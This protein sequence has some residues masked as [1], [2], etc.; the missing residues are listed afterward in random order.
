MLLAVSRLYFPFF[1]MTAAWLHTCCFFQCDPIKK[2]T[3]HY[4]NPL[5]F[6]SCCL[7]HF[8]WCAAPMD[9]SKYL[10]FVRCIIE[11]DKQGEERSLP[12][13][14]TW[15]TATLQNR[16]RGSVA[17]CLLFPRPPVLTVIQFLS[18][19]SQDHRFRSALWGSACSWNVWY[20]YQWRNWRSVTG[21]QIWNWLSSSLLV[22]GI[23]C[24]DN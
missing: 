15:N 1:I 7:N 2:K 16:R 13:H 5:L 22:W 18:L 14:T 8:L 11:G 23:G 9:T 6:A 21:Q 4:K 19:S 10:C 20:W 3:Q 24:Q 17:L 12:I